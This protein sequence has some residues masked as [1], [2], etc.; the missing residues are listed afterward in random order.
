M[1]TENKDVR[2][3]YRAEKRRGRRP[4]DEERQKSTKELKQALE[5]AIRQQ[6]ERAFLTALRRAGVK[7][8]TNEFARA[9]QL[10]REMIGRP[11]KR[12]S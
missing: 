10:F 4:I 6:D 12:S 11:W 2:D 7:D 3:V 8:G 1:T 9:V 5:Q